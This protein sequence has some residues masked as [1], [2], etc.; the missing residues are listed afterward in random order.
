[1]YHS[2]FKKRKTKMYNCRE[3]RED[4]YRTSN[5]VCSECK[6]RE[7]AKANVL[8]KGARNGLVKGIGKGPLKGK[9]LG[10]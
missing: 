9:V 6:E 10:F 7:K 1:M 5:E 3:S 2:R 4:K 8:G